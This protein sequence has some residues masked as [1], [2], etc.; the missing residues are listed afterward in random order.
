MEKSDQKLLW[1]MNII[2]QGAKNAIYTGLTAND[3]THGVK[4]S[5]DDFIHLVQIA[6]SVPLLEHQLQ[7]ERK[8]N[9]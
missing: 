6:S 8:K 7:I 9:V 1:K 4:L 5:H 2:S 3:I